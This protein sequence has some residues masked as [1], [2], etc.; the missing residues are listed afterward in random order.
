MRG[1]D[2]PV[3][4]VAFSWRNGVLAS[5]GADQLIRL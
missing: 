5:G 2:C 3:F 4:T 1:Y